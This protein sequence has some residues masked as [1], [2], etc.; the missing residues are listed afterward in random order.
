VKRTYVYRLIVTYPE[1]SKDPGWE[2]PG[3]TI[4]GPNGY[5]D[6]GEFRWP[7]QRCYLSLSGARNARSIFEAYGARVTIERSEPVTWPASRADG[8]S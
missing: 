6:S 5:K 4:T 1:G 8:A 7:R 2:P 3:W